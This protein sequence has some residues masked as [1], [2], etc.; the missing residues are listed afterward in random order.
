[1]VSSFRLFPLD[2]YRIADRRR[3]IY[4]KRAIHNPDTNAASPLDKQAR[5]EGGKTRT[6]TPRI[7]TRNKPTTRATAFV[8]P[9]DKQDETHGRY[10][11][12]GGKDEVQRSSNG[13]ESDEND[14]AP[15]CDKQDEAMNETTTDGTR[16]ET[17][18]D[19]SSSSIL[20]ITTLSPQ[21][22]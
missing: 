14:N 10:E 3:V 16:N 21:L 4:T 2:I 17:G 9:H 20:A 11:D 1:M 5:N 18:D 12:D 19:Y 6:T 8:S 15:P 7:R 22:S 13:A